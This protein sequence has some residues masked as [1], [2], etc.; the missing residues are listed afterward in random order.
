MTMTHGSRT[1]AGRDRE[2]RSTSRYGRSPAVSR[3]FSTAGRAASASALDER[4][5]APTESRQ[6]SRVALNPGTQQPQRRRLQHKT[7]SQQVI[8]V[9]GRQVRTRR[10]DRKLI[11]LFSAVILLMGFG[12]ALSMGLSG[13]STQQTFELQQLKSQETELSNRIES[14]NRDVEQARSAGTLAANATDLGMVAPVAPGVLAVGEQGEIIEERPA[15][16]EVRAIIDI[17]G[18]QARPNR[19][20]SNPDET[21]AVSEN[22]REIPQGAATPPYQGGTVPYAA[23]VRD[24]GQQA[25]GIGQ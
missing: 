7:G 25:G 11:R 8:S 12:V 16:P 9:R 22:L 20:S 14:L 21:S 24:A 5:S 6:R 18:E 15:D 10:A 2:R 3:D 1:D 4:R 17:N 23:T 19:A 13:M